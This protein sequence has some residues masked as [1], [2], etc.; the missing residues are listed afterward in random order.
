M[1]QSTLGFLRVIGFVEGLSYLL[2]LFVAMPLKYFFDIPSWVRVVGMAHGG[3][4]VLFVVALLA[5]WVRH[6]W[7]LLRVAGAF[8]AC[9]LPFGTFFLDS[10]LKKEMNA[11]ER[12]ILQNEEA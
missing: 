9:L 4:F 10:H 8:L 6:R 12:Y 1:W 2:L 7:N 11:Q 3:L 5:V